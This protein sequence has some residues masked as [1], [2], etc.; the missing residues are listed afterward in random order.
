[1]AEVAE[2][3][4]VVTRRRILEEFEK[5]Q[6]QI[7]ANPELRTK[8]SFE[9][10]KNICE[11][12]GDDFID[13]P[14][15][16]FWF[17]RFA[18]GNFGL[19]YDRSSD[20]KTRSFTDLPLDVFNKIGEN[21][22]LHDRFQLRNVCKD[23]RFQVDNWDPK[24]T[25]I[26]YCKGHWA[27][28]QTEL[29]YFASSIEEY[30]IPYSFYRNPV[31]LVLNILRLPKL[32]LEKLEIEEPDEYWKKLIEE[33]DE[34]NRK[35]HVKKVEF[36]SLSSSKIDLHFMIPGVLE[37]IEMF[38]ENPKR[39][40]IFEIIESEQCQ[41]AKMLYIYSPTPTS[42]F[43]L[44][45]LYNCPRFTLTLGGKP[46]GGL[47][48]KFLKKLMKYGD[49]QKCAVY[50][51]REIMKYFNEPEAMVPNFP[52]LRRYPIPGTNEFYELEYRVEG[53]RYLHQFVNLER[54]Q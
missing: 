23:V 42:R 50:A 39:E 16:E 32:Q 41:K 9:A 44:E 24:V 29:S 2:R 13:Y 1:M 30:N 7:A 12:M 15:F 17:S 14:E 4:Q 8:L 51:Q 37:E 49:V 11:T 47:K 54:T 28:F 25:N 43:P 19:D 20:P 36:P 46:A 10:H 27:V 6:A 33:L 31:Y 34:S 40:E 18:R 3:D 45:P 52:S 21:L 38:V 5:V 48:A 35:L 26:E 22:K 53:N